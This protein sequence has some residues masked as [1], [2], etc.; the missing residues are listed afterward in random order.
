MKLSTKV[1]RWQQ[2]GEIVNAALHARRARAHYAAGDVLTC[3][4]SRM[5]A[6][7][8]RDNVLWRF[9]WVAQ[10]RRYAARVARIRAGA[11]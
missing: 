6:R 2:W 9:R 1:R 11:R 3:S 7:E 10:C 4:I 8:F 5:H